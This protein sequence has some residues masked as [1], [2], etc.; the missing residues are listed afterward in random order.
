MTWVFNVTVTFFY[1]PLFPQTQLY[2]LCILPQIPSALPVRSVRRESVC[3]T[4]T[5]IRIGA[6]V[7]SLLFLQLSCVVQGQEEE[8]E[9]SHN[10]PGWAVSFWS[11]STVVS[12]VL[13]FHIFVNLQTFIINWLSMLLFSQG[14]CDCRLA[15]TVTTLIRSS[16][17]LSLHFGPCTWV[18]Y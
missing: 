2:S 6:P 7:L 14:E 11:K 18:L 5:D 9:C 15:D 17:F 12:V 8:D 13:A 3:Q 16:T 10:A 1:L 4:V